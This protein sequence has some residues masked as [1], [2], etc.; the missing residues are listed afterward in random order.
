MRRK[1]LESGAASD[2]RYVVLLHPDGSGRDYAADAPMGMV[3]KVG[4]RH[5][6]PFDL[7][8]MYVFAD[9]VLVE[10]RR[11]SNGKVKE[12]LLFRRTYYFSTQLQPAFGRDPE[13]NLARWRAIG[14]TEMG[15]LLELAMEQVTDM[16]AYDFS[17]AGRVEGAQRVGNAARRLV[18]GEQVYGRVLREEPTWY[19]T[20]IAMY[21][22][23]EGRYPL[24]GKARATSWR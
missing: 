11:K 22:D 21:G 19:W 1:L 18:A 12:R 24:E 10:R 13:T 14:G 8:Q 15:R 16:V 4:Q 3:L 20:R 5:A 7:G 23:I 6:V 9:V 17:P 2:T